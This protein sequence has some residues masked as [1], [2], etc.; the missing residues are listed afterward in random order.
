M[1]P[2]IYALVAEPMP[3]CQATVDAVIMPSTATARVQCQRL[4]GETSGEGG[5]MRTTRQCLPCG[6][7]C[8][9]FCC[10]PFCLGGQWSTSR[11][12]GRRCYEDG[13]NKATQLP[14]SFHDSILV[15][16]PRGTD[17]LELASWASWVRRRPPPPHFFHFILSPLNH[18]LCFAGRF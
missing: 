12:V 1:E 17:K 15:C 10:G 16:T 5:D 9:A 8:R 18:H 7:P 6:P 4:H 11:C 3:S 2:F 13:N 14:P